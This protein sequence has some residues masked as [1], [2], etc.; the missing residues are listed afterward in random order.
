M[1]SR[2][3]KRIPDANR[4]DMRSNLELTCRNRRNRHLNGF[5]AQTSSN[6]TAQT[7]VLQPMLTLLDHEVGIRVLCN[8]VH[9]IQMMHMGPQMRVC[10]IVTKREWM[11]KW[12]LATVRT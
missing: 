7:A 3:R 10:F 1:G 9:M 4:K 5:G 6:V 2:G 8:H 12:A 11:L